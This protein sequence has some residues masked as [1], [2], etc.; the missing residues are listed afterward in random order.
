MSNLYRLIAVVL[1]LVGLFIGINAILGI[2]GIVTMTSAKI[3]EKEQLDTPFNVSLAECWL[4]DCWVFG[5]HSSVFGFHDNLLLY[6][7]K[8]PRG[9]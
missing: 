8:T 7:I 9:W 1:I 4:F 6:R 2:S 5:F 3:N